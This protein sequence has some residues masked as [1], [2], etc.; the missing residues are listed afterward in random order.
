MSSAALPDDSIRK[1][2]CREGLRR[3]LKR[4]SRRSLANGLCRFREWLEGT[5][6]STDVA[7]EEVGLD[8]KLAFRSSPS[9]NNNL[10]MVLRALPICSK[11]NVIDV[12]CGKG[13]AMRVMLEFPFARVSGVEISEQLADV[14]RRNFVRLRIPLDRWRVVA[15]N[16]TVFDDWDHYNYVYF[17]A[18]FPSVVMAEVVRNLASSLQRVPRKTTIIYNNPFCHAEIVSS[19][20]FRKIAEYPV[21][22]RIFVYSNEA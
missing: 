2:R 11:D 18:P 4:L 9:G 17:Y 19:G 8:P 3:I 10:R 1:R 16:A 20:M 21:D 15:A 5:D 7:P 12:G 22:N 13:S 6:F 14:A